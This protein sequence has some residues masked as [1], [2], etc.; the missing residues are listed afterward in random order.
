MVDIPL[1]LPTGSTIGRDGQDANA[2]LINAYAEPLGKDGKAPFA[3]YNAPGSRRWDDGSFSGGCRDLIQVSSNQLIGVLGNE[4]VSFDQAGV[5]A[6]IETIAGSGRVMT[7]INRAATPQIPILTSA[8]QTS[9]LAGGVLTPMSDT[10]LPTTISNCYLA[11]FTIYGIEDGRIFQSDLENASSVLADAFGIARGD[12]S[13]LVRVLPNAGFLYAMKE[14]TTEIWQPDP[15]LAA[16]NFTFSPVQQNIDI[17]LGAR[18]SPAALQ[19]GLA[20]VDDEYIV[21]LGRDGAAERISSH[22]VERSIEDLTQ[23]ERE[24]LYGFVHTFQG[25]ECYVLTATGKWTW[26]LDSATGQWWERQSYDR[27]GWRVNSHV[28]FNKQHI[29]G[30]PDN[31]NLYVIDPKTPTD[32]DESQVVEIWCAQSHR[33]PKAMK[34]DSLELDI[35]SGVGVTPNGSGIYFHDG[36]HVTMGDVLDRT[37]SFT[38]EAII[39]PDG[40]ARSGQRIVSKDT[41]TAGWSLSLGDGGSGVLRFFHRQL[42]T[43][44]TDAADAI[45]AGVNRHVA[46]VFNATADTVTLYIDG[47]QSAQTTG[48]TNAITGNSAVLAIGAD[49][50]NDAIAGAFHFDGFIREVRIWDVARTQAE[51]SANMQASLTG[52]ETGLSGY[53]KL[54]EQNGATAND[55]SPSG[56]DGTLAGDAVWSSAYWQHNAD[57]KIMVDYSDDGGHSFRGERSASMGKIGNYRQKVRLNRWG[58]VTE[59]GRIWRFRAS[60]DV[61][62]GF[63]GAVLQGEALDV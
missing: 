2:R 46:A 24:A 40:V 54:D 55:S 62:R 4:I 31:G 1:T 16:E 49:P 10:D 51:I 32:A 28:V 35:I 15:S 20:W 61:L 18:F 56:F 44:I 50:L 30:T 34:V 53:W 48:Q 43:I 39:N 38:V 45:V 52:S 23:A 25:H 8:G 13:K 26:V 19:R 21:R 14:K 36:S 59:K 27:L 57:P 7:S 22:S 42:N 47:V 12:S 29:V 6:L 3:V 9:I 5:S 41:G 11:G 58:R 60:A 17:G 33:F 63:L 37:G